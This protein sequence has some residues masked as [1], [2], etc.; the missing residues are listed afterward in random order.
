L[1]DSFCQVFLHR[2]TVRCPASVP[3]QFINLGVSTFQV[4]FEFFPVLVFFFLLLGHTFQ[5]IQAF[6]F[7]L[8]LFKDLVTLRHGAAFSI[9]SEGVL[10]INSLTGF[11]VFPIG[12]LAPV[13]LSCPHVHVTNR[14]VGFKVVLI[15]WAQFIKQGV[16]LGLKDLAGISYHIVGNVAKD[17]VL[18]GIN[19]FG[20]DN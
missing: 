3:H 15:Q 5:S 16:N 9:P 7:F 20:H 6:K 12:Q 2:V 4:V 14:Q 8:T 19:S 13:R 17:I 11:V 10:V 18:G 1:W